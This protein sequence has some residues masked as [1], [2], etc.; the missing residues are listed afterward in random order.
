MAMRSFSFLL[1]SSLLAASAC[2]SEAV[3]NDA[4]R[5]TERSDGDLSHRASMA[6]GMF[7]LKLDCSEQQEAEL[8]AIAQGALPDEEQRAEHARAMRTFADAFRADDLDTETLATL[9]SQRVVDREHIRDSLL[10]AHQVLDADQRDELA[11]ML[12]SGFGPPPMAMA[13]RRAEPSKVAEHMAA[14]LCGVAACD[15]IQEGEITAAIADG[16]PKPSEDDTTVMRRRV[17]EVVRTNDLDAKAL[18]QLAAAFEAKRAR[19]R[20]QALNTLSEVH[21][22]LNPEQR[23]A[24]A[25]TLEREGPRGL[26]GP[27]SLHD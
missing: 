23:D 22:I 20:P 18:D 21:S 6:I 24:V 1:A 8:T 17:A 16:M 9:H 3:D 10:A 25:T 11:E 14:R 2:D 27:G 7:C 19:F 13:M 4:E 15:E 5:S 12:D 26:L